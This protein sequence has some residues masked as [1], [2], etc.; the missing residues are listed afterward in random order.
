MRR[1][2]VFTGRARNTNFFQA[3]Q[4]QAAD[5]IPG[6]MGKSPNRRALQDAA[7]QDI[8]VRKI[9]KLKFAKLYK[10][11]KQAARKLRQVQAMRQAHNIRQAT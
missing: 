9:P 6:Q 10:L 5:G 11:A 4:Q 1:D 8:A 3:S 7:L 2:A